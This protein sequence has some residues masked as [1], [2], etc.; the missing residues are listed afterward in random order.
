LSIILA[1]AFISACAVPAACAAGEASSLKTSI[2]SPSADEYAVY[3]D[4]INSRYAKDGV[5]LIV[6]EDHTSGE[7]DGIWEL[8]GIDG[9]LLEDYQARN[10]AEY[11]LERLFSLKTSYELI[12]EGEALD[13]LSDYE[14]AWDTFY[15][16]YPDSQGILILS[17]VGF[18]KNKTQALVY[19][20]NQAGP[21]A[22][23]G[24]YYL[25]VRNGASWIVKDVFEALI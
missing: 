3:S 25:L 24:N 22:I 2:T 6:V 1:A 19:A 11:G 17:R 16:I 23:D 4:L 7:S 13:T 10:K 21:A 8:H 5:S 14:G 18:D 9:E 20:C 15:E 12:S